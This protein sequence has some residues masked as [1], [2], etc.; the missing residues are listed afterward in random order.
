MF[1]KSGRSL[2]HVHP[3][4]TES[5]FMDRLR[6]ALRAELGGTRTATKT[7]MRWTDACERTARNWMTGVGGP[8]GYHLLCL[9]R[10][11]GQVFETILNFAERT[12]LVLAA[13]MHA[14][15]VALAKA[16][17]TFEILRRQSRQH[18]SS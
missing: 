5:E 16:N 11:S 9:A 15:E 12:D 14:I 10:E 7:I 2:P 8:S 13:D 18:V 4:P 17:G 6:D 1:P 3:R